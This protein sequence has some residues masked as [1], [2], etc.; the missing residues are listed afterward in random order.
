MR[1]H[2]VPDGATRMVMCISVVFTKDCADDL[3]L[4]HYV[5]I[6][7]VPRRII[8]HVVVVVVVPSLFES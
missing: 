3:L 1:L 2:A 4:M 6:V 8:P 7:I 5:V